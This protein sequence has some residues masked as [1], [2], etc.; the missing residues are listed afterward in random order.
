LGDLIVKIA[1]WMYLVAVDREDLIIRYLHSV[2]HDDLERTGEQFRVGAMNL[3][4][5]ALLGGTGTK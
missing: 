2:K 5:V 4:A 1:L 3:P